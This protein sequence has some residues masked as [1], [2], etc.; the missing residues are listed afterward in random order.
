MLG[1]A[2]AS[3]GPPKAHAQAL[4]HA[5]P[6][7]QPVRHAPLATISPPRARPRLLLPAGGLVIMEKQ[8]ELIGGLRELLKT[9]RYPPEAKKNRVEGEILVSFVVNE[10]GRVEQAV[11]EEGLDDAI[12]EEILRAVRQAQFEPG[13]QTRMTPDGNWV[14]K[15]VP[16]RMTLP[17]TFTL[18]K[19]PLP[20]LPQRLWTW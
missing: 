10:V 13:T 17:F 3:L 2:A 6:R 19:V 18:H 7:L 14:R 20:E 16:V 15:T 5:E 9:V 12:N 1:V 11:I 8:P 4:A